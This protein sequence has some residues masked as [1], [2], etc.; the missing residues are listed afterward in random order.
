MT[1]QQEKWFVFSEHASTSPLIK[2]FG[3]VL[4]QVLEVLAIL[5]TAVKNVLPLKGGGGGRGREKFYPALNRDKK[6]L[7]PDFAIL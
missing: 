4:T 7:I 1:L 2:S 5:M 3:V 6:S